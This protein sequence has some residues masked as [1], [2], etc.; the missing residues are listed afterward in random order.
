MLGL[1]GVQVNESEGV[2]YRS[3]GQLAQNRIELGFCKFLKALPQNHTL[4]NCLS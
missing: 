3:E 4:P 1:G 2:G